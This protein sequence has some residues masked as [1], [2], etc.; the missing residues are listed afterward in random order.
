MRV[1]NE[2]KYLE[3]SLES[4]RALCAPVVVLDDGSTDK[5]SEI[6]RGFEFVKYHKQDAREMNEAR[7]RGFIFQ[8]AWEL[9]PEWVLT[10]DGDEM[11][12]KRTPQAIL[13]HIENIG[14]QFNIIHLAIAFMWHDDWCVDFDTGPFWHHRMY[15]CTEARGE[16]IFESMK[17]H[18]APPFGHGLHCGPVPHLENTWTVSR[19][20]AFLKA[21]GYDTREGYEKHFGFYQ[22]YDPS[23]WSQNEIVQRLNNP[24]VKWDA[25]AVPHERTRE[26]QLMYLIEKMDSGL[27]QWERVSNEQGKSEAT[28]KKPVRK[29]KAVGHKRQPKGG[30]KKLRS[31]PRS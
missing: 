28:A 25:D 12:P 7:D 17:I 22:Q 24:L 3:R 13:D 23:L 27:R 1:K 14:K 29:S 11:L 5:T 26:E 20:P 4:M 15:R 10:V 9:Q 21:Y 16:S 19:C 18:G 6:A 2:E 31:S 8:R 30:T